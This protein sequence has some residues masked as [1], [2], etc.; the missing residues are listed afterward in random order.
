M[1]SIFGLVRLD[2]GEA[3]WDGRRIGYEERRRFG[4]MP[5][6]RG[7]YPRMRVLDQVSYFGRLHG[8]DAPASLKSSMHWIERLGVADKSQAKLEE[9]SHGN[10]QR[11]QLAVALVARPDLLVLD[12]PFAGLDPIGVEALEEAIREE[13]RRGAAVVFSSHQL[14][15]VED[16][17][18]DIAIIHQGRIVMH[19]PLLEIRQASLYRYVQ[20]VLI[21]GAGETAPAASL[22][23]EGVEVLWERNGEMRFRVPRDADPRVLLAAA[24]GLGD[25]GY[26]RFE[27]P[28][29]SDLFREAV[30]R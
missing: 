17:C 26:F 3:L 24:C 7:L 19:G 16:I 15:L 28:K 1:R 9:L 20:L 10:Q 2:E 18:D 22:S 12:E 5:E 30:E 21:R 8:L 27:P 29:L 6:E 23:M 11:V 25:V 13:A 4:Y 14:D